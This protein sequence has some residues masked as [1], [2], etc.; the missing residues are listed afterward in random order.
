MCSCTICPIS[1]FI[2]YH[3]VGPVLNF[4]QLLFSDNFNLGLSA[5]GVF[6]FI[7]T[8]SSSFSTLHIQL[9]SLFSSIF[10]FRQIMKRKIIIEIIQTFLIGTFHQ[11]ATRSH[12][13]VS[14]HSMGPSHH[15][16]D[17]KL[18]LTT[19]A[20]TEKLKALEGVQTVWNSPGISYRDNTQFSYDILGWNN[21]ENRLPVVK[22]K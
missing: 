7:I 4:L 8:F 5:T 6:G 3:N 14:L 15:P 2:G 21:V 1:I 22:L 20:W 12:Q 9:F 16:L 11:I 10:L 17:D 19:M 13:L 18:H